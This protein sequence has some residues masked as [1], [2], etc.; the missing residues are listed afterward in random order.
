VAITHTHVDHN[1]NL[2]RSVDGRYA[3]GSYL[4]NGRLNGSGKLDAVWMS[5]YVVAPGST[6]R[7]DDVLDSEVEAQGV[8]GLSNSD[9]ID[10][11]ACESVDP[12]IRILAGGR[13]SKPAG[14]TKDDFD[15]G[16]NHS[17]VIR[18]DF[19]E[20]SF[21]FTGD[22]EEA[23]MRDLVRR[24][25]RTD[26][27][28]TDVLLVS[29]HGADN[30]TPAEFL[31]AVTPEIAVISMGPEAIHDDWTAY[32]YGHPRKTTVLKL[33]GAVSGSRPPRQVAVATG[34]R[35]FE[36]LEMEKAVYGT[37]WDG[38]IVLTAAPDGKISV[39]TAH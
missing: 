7:P 8:S 21:L 33:V 4:H 6:I 35:S 39:V 14:W 31:A 32:A 10:R 1:V 9:T 38:D 5:N 17:L 15:E 3:V 23:G 20:S 37:G 26:L 25:A 24:Y 12:K 18:I 22:L 28:D 27:L 11:I 29:H 36:S 19:E 2:R 30:G 13:T 16:N 34:Q